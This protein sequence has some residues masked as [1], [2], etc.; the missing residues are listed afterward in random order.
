M[1]KVLRRVYVT[2]ES[3]KRMRKFA[4]E[5]NADLCEAYDRLILTSINESGHISKSELG[6]AREEIETLA[7]KIGFTIPETVTLLARTVK[8]LYSDK[9]PFYKAIRGLRELEK[10]AAK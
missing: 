5:L 6:E 2:E 7:R 3:D 1:G 9:L 10:I 8:T 4:A